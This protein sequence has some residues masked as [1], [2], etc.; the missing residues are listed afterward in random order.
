MSLSNLSAVVPIGVVIAQSLEGKSQVQQLLYLINSVLGSTQEVVSEVMRQV[1]NLPAQT[2][3]LFLHML[4]STEGL[5]YQEVK[6]LMAEVKE[7]LLE[8]DLMRLIEKA[9]KDEMLK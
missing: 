9:Q 5:S 1:W 3:E 7:K 6:E 8:D 4:A 2:Y